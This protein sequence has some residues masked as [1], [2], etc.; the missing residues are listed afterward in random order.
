MVD[1]GDQVMGQVEHDQR[2]DLVELRVRDGRDLVARQIQMLEGALHWVQRLDRDL[3]QVV[4]TGP[5]D[6]EAGSLEELLRQRGQP[7][8]R[9]TRFSERK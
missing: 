9:V 5:E 8:V 6:L 3:V 7:V 1:G 4:M 2:L